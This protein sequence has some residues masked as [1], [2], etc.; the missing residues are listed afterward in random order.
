MKNILVGVISK[1]HFMTMI[2]TSYLMVAPDC[3]HTA[4]HICFYF[5][6]SKTPYLRPYVSIFS[7]IGLCVL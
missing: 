7:H 3:A 4:Y 5:L 1:N 6:G 2:F